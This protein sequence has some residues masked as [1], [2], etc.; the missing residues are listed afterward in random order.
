LIIKK[1]FRPDFKEFILDESL[2]NQ[3]KV[4]MMNDNYSDLFDQIA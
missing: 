4:E 2:S 3:E 1:R